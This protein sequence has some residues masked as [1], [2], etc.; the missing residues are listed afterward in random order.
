MVKGLVIPTPMT[1]TDGSPGDS[2]QALTEVVLVHFRT[3]INTTPERHKFRQLKQLPDEPVSSF[4]GRLRVK[5]ELCNFATTDMD[6]VVNTQVRDQ[7]IMW[8][9]TCLG[10]LF[11]PA[12]QSLCPSCNK[13]DHFAGVCLSSGR[14]SSYQKTNA[15]EGTQHRLRAK[16]NMARHHDSRCGV[17]TLPNFKPVVQ[18]NCC[19]PTKPWAVVEQYGRQVGVSYGTRVFPPINDMSANFKLLLCAAMRVWLSVH[20][21]KAV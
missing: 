19:D 5:V 16:A 13:L 3:S 18:N 8:T 17:Q 1:N 6:S 9:V 11:C 4:V 20:G 12:A 14:S 21:V 2:Y 7:L 10:K 15:V